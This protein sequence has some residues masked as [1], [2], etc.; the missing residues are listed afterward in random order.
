V[1]IGNLKQKGITEGCTMDRSIKSQCCTLLDV[2]KSN[3]FTGANAT[4]I[5]PREHHNQR[6][7]HFHRSVFQRIEWPRIQRGNFH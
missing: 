5:G 7:A 4:P 3:H 1:P 2:V 6:Q